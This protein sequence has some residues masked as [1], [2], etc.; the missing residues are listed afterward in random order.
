MSLWHLYMH[1]L[2]CSLEPG[3]PYEVTIQQI[4]WH[5]TEHSCTILS[6]YWLNDDLPTKLPS[7]QQFFLYPLQAFDAPTINDSGPKKRVEGLVG[8][9]RNRALILWGLRA[10]TPRPHS[11]SQS[12]EGQLLSDGKPTPLCK[13]RW[14]SAPDYLAVWLPLPA[15]DTRLQLWLFNV[16][17][18]LA[19]CSKAE[20][21]LFCFGFDPALWFQKRWR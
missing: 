17:N 20:A 19:A 2:A 21:T 3:R 7:H 10:K 11:S 6:I 15:Q 8:I 5:K 1:C 14:L 18:C 16:T 9:D 13:S 4:D 12:D